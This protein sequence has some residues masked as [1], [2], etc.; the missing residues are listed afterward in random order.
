MSSQTE[1]SDDERSEPFL[2]SWRLV[3]FEH[4]TATGEVS[5]PFGNEPSGL[6]LYQA[7]GHM[8]AHVCAGGAARLVSDDPLAAS[9]QEALAAWRSYFGY[10]G[11]F[12]IDAEKGVVVHRVTGSSFPN[13]IG[14]DQVR[15][16]RFDGPNRLILEARSAA[17]QTTA[18]WQR[19]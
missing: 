8:S 1:R 9:A 6:I 12:A 17:G 4:T 19:G 3:S 18:I 2:G 5:K 7:D 14:T 13:W 10:W 11:S 16:F 15:Y